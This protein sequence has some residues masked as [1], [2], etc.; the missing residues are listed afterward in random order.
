M[1]DKQKDA[2]IQIADNIPGAEY[3]NV[4]QI[5]HNQEEFQL[6]FLSIAG[7]SGRV[8]SKVITTPSHFKRLVA[9]MAD[10]LK[11][12]EE[13]FGEV[14]EIAAINEKEIGFKA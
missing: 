12:Y 7:P 5:N 13:Q 4:A 6:T 9:A 10:N 14:K 8:V 11:K 3:S 2:Q 1:T